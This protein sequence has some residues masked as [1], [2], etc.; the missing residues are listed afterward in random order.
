MLARSL[1]K[2]VTRSVRPALYSTSSISQAVVLEDLPYPYDSLEP[3]IGQKTLHIHHDKHHA[4]YVTT[5][6]DLIKGTELENDDVVTLIRKAHQAKNTA[7]F[8]NAGQSFNHD[9]YWK[10]MKPKGGGKPTGKLAELIEK[11]LGGYD[12]FRQEFV[13]AATTAFG[14]G[15]AWLVWTPKGLKV[16]QTIGAGNP[17]TEE[18]QVPLLTIDVW[19]HAYYLDYQ[20]LRPNYIDTFLDH[21]VNWD[22]VASRLPK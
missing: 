7:L 11:D 21:L 22:A 4:R 16:T 20:N 12:K 17:W 3:H 14:S 8:N 19:E 1:A 18:G 10:S 13:K 2:T 15:W 6:N 5:A 9:F